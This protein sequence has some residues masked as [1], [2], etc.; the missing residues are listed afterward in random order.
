MKQS[1]SVDERHERQE[2]TLFLSD[3]I[4]KIPFINTY[5]IGLHD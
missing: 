2:N 3:D 4:V 5:Q 1:F